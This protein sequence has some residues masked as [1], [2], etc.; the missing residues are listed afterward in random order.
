MI[1]S[2]RRK[3]SDTTAHVELSMLVEYRSELM[4]PASVSMQRTRHINHDV[5]GHCVGYR[6]ICVL[7]EYI[8]REK[9]CLVAS[10]VAQKSVCEVRGGL[11]PKGPRLLFRGMQC[12]PCS[13]QPYRVLVRCSPS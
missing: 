11:V 7:C 9:E 1:Y 12:R 3:A 10:G 8:R 6:G 4:L 2:V 13:K 5:Y